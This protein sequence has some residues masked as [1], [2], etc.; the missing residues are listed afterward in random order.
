MKK[1]FLHP[2]VQILLAGTM[3]VLPALGQTVR[4]LPT[5]A[6]V[7]RELKGGETHSYRIQLTAGQCLHAQAEQENIELV[8]AIF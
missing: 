2:L 3:C 5:L 4:D 7:Q 1:K 8:T 6:P